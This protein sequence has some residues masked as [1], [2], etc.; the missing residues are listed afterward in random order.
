M[1]VHYKWE[2]VP[3][4]EINWL[5]NVSISDEQNILKILKVGKNPE[6]VNAVTLP[7]NAVIAFF[8][9]LVLQ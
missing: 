6:G 9:Y 7:S 1:R 5:N 2:N 4:Q 8:E 3:L